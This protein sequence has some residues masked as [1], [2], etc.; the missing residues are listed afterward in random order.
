MIHRWRKLFVITFRV[1]QFH[2]YP[3]TGKG[4]YPGQDVLVPYI[5]SMNIEANGR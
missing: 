5:F 3:D 2:E 4:T 1:C